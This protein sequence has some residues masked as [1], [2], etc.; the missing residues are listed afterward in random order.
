[1]TVRS[2]SWTDAQRVSSLLA[3]VSATP[4]REPA[5]LVSAMGSSRAGAP[6][7]APPAPA[8]APPKAPKEVPR[9][10]Q[11]SDNPSDRLDAL[12]AWTLAHHACAGA[13]VADDNGL[14]LAAHGISEAH[15]SLVGPL[16]SALVGV[17][18]VPGVDATAGALWLGA[19]MMSWVETRTARG[20]FC[21][22]TVGDEALSTRALEQ[23]KEAL[24]TT[25]RGL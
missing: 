20:G 18:T 15:V 10:V 14:T 7:K 23:L 22:G 2:V 11:T 4:A 17:R 3:R 8:K 5:A 19:Q 12:V 21:L 1:M 9:L 16:L 25:V 6:A 24:E 13:F